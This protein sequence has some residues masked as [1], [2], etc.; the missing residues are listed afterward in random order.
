M[1]KNTSAYIGCFLG[2]AVGDAM[3]YTVDDKAWEEICDNYGPNGLLGYD[4]QDDFAQ[5][6]SYTQMAAFTANGLLLGVTRGRRSEY[7]KFITL[8]LREWYK[9]QHFPRS[10]DKSWFWVAQKPELRR[11]HCRDAWMMDAL[12]FETPGTMDK[13]VN[14][15]DSPGAMLSAAAVAL[16][17]DPRRMEPEQVGELTAKVLAM[18][19]GNPDAFLSGVVLAYALT[20]I[21]Q[22]PDR[23]LEE[24]FLTA[25]QVMAGQ[26]G[27]RFAQAQTIAELVKSAVRQAREDTGEHRQHMEDYQCRTAPECLAGAVYASLTFPE[28]FDSAMI[29]AVNHS[30]RSAAVGAITGAVLGAKL[31]QEAL[32]EFYL[33]SLEPIESLRQLAQDLAVGS[34]ATGLFDDDWDQKYTHGIPLNG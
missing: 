11:R 24:Q 27:E 7:L 29:L 22:E 5:V 20:G 18:T 8:A 12:R 6:T 30:G 31:G 21:L 13:P 33:E 2:L 17:Y 10:P 26:F 19:H 16:F 32:P 9:R 15:S 4:L 14:N 23:P 25:A 3:G 1:G 34:P 28:D